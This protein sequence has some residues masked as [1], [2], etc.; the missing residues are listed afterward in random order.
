MSSEKVPPDMRKMCRFTTSC[1]CTVSSG[2][3]LSIETSIVLSGS[4]Y[5]QQKPRSNCTDAQADLGLCC[6]HMP[7]DV[8]SHG[9]AHIDLFNVI[10]FIL[11]RLFVSLL[12]MILINCV[13]CVI[14]CVF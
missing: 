7:E 5:G 11:A 6:L 2:H 10:V 8:F 13:K 9:A 3:L 14:I 4:V 12:T 1:T